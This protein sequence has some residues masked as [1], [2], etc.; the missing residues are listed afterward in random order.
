MA[1]SKTDTYLIWAGEYGVLINGDDGNNQIIPFFDY[2]VWYWNTDFLEVRGGGGWH[3][4]GSTQPR[5]E[6]GSQVLAHP[7]LTCWFVFHSVLGS[8]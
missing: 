7:H 3:P 8:E 1:V 4:R 5:T 2:G 6:A